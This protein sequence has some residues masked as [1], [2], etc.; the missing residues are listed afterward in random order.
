MRR[1]SAI[2]LGCLFLFCGCGEKDGHLSEGIAFRSKLVQQNGCRFRAE[3]TADKGSDILRFCLDCEGDGQ[4]NVSFVLTEPETLAGISG[5][6]SEA[7]GKIT[8]DGMSV[9]FGLLLQDAIAPAAAPA[10]LVNSWIS[11]YMLWG[12]KDGETYCMCCEQVLEGR[13]LEVESFFKNELPFYAEVCY[14][15]SRILEI[16]IIDFQYH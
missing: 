6:I 1:L 9:D 2:L 4:G 12:G 10:L 16:Q 11:G 14:N 7:G 5:T 8:Y 15:G 3:I 13:S